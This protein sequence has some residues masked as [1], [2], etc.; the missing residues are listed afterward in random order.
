MR[1]FP[2][3]GREE[4]FRFFTLTPADVAFIDP[5]RGPADRLGLAVTLCTLPWLGFV[6]DEVAAAPRAAVVRLAEQLQV[7]PDHIR[8]YGRRAKTRTEHLRSVTRYLGWRAPTTLELK[9]LDEFLLAR[10]LEHDSPLLLF[11]LACDYLISARVIRPGPVTVVERVA[12]AR[13]EARRETF[14][15]LAHE[16]T[17]QRCADL[18]G[19]LVDD[20]A[21]GTT[22]LRWLATGPVEASPAAVKAEVAKLEFLRGLDAHTLELSVLPAERR[23]FLATVGRRLTAQALQRREPQRRYPILL[24]LLA[25]SATDVLDE[26]VQ[27][28]D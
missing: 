2:E 21:I 1:K 6:P 10:A 5:G 22:R 25:Q 11:R 18:D 20:P 16:F 14:D 7:D 15:R 3:I 12:H 27:L 17:D 23:R 19:L 9:E 28:F 4:L 8:S 13:E 26:V 24:T